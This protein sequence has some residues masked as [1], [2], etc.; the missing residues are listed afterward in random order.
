[1]IEK[2]NQYH[3]IFEAITGVSFDWEDH[4]PVSMDTLKD[5]EK[6][7]KKPEKETYEYLY[8]LDV[9]RDH[10]DEKRKKC[11]CKGTG[12]YD[13]TE[14]P[15]F[16]C[17]GV[18]YRSK[19]KDV[20]NDINDK[21]KD[22]SFRIEMK[23]ENGKLKGKSKKDYEEYYY[24]GSPDNDKKIGGKIWVTGI[25]IKSHSNHNDLML[26]VKASDDGKEINE[27]DFGQ[28]VE[29][30]IPTDR[31]KVRNKKIEIKPAEKLNIYKKTDDW[32]FSAKDKKEQQKK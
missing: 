12:F 32:W 5:I 26:S 29:T 10:Q 13:E 8:I 2:F 18:G 17:G 19:I 22:K 16:N 27:Y 14:E 31:L 9:L 28:W 3:K 11:S 4:I 21:I 20:L 24:D 15:C 7:A 1:M 23:V 25:F 6:S 30:I